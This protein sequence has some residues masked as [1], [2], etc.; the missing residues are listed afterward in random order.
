MKLTEAQAYKIRALSAELEAAR[1]KER[2]ATERLNAAFR[3]CGL[4][5]SLHAVVMRDG[6][7]LPV[8]TVLLAST[9]QPLADK[10]AP[11][12]V[13]QRAPR[14]DP[15]QQPRTG[16]IIGKCPDCTDGMALIAGFEEPC[17]LCDGR[18]NLRS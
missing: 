14:V 17:D 10:P 16:S 9:G 7:S 4:D 2:L 3:A 5:P 1:A 12:G 18:G 13:A 6:E 8:G 11:A 15:P